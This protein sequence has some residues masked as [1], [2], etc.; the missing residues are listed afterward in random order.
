[1]Y[2]I[3]EILIILKNSNLEDVQKIRDII[4]KYKKNYNS[5]DYKIL[6]GLIDF[7]HQQLSN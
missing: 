5:E 2:T 4:A 7:I 3:E 1:M 6:I